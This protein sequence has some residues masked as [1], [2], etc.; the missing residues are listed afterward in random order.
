VAAAIEQA[1]ESRA[2]R[3]RRRTLREYGWPSVLRRMESVIEGEAGD[4]G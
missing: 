3:L 2:A 4:G 1:L